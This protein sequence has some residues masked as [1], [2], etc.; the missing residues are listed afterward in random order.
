MENFINRKKSLEE[1]I[2]LLEW[3]FAFE[4]RT[5][6]RNKIRVYMNKVQ[7]ELLLFLR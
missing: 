5:D 2:Q 4:H 7:R 1:E 6:M 3:L